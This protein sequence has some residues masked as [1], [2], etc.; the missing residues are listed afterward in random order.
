MTAQLT[1][2]A[3]ETPKQKTPAG[4]HR[5]VAAS[6]AGTVAE[7]YEF[8]L[9]GMAAAL[10]F[11]DVFFKATGNPLDG[12]IAALLTYAIGF[13][14]RPI[15]G[16]IFGHYGDKFGRKKLLQVS[17]LVIGVST[18]LIGAI[19]SFDQIGYA[20]PIILVVLRF[21][22]GIAIGG[23]WGGAVLLVAEQSPDD[24]R[25][26]WASFPQVGAPLGN[27]LA[28]VVL[29]VLSFALPEAAFL[30]W[31]WRVAFFFSAF[32]V[33]IGWFIRTK[34]EDSPIFQDAAE[35]QPQA[36]ST[37]KAIKRVFQARPREV[38]TAMGARVIENILYYM[39]VTFSLTYLKV[40][41][42]VDTSTILTL[43]LISHIVH[44]AMILVFGWMSDKVGRRPVYLAGA[45]LATVYCF[46]AFPLMD[47]KSDALILCAITVGLIIH[48][49]MYAPQPALLSEMFPT[50]MRYIGVSLGAQVTA[51][52]AG[53]LA[54]VIATMLL[55]TFDSW[56]PIA[57]YVAVAGLISIVA[58]LF[59]RETKGTSLAALDDEHRAR[60]G[61][62]L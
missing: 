62:S 46:V 17:L 1:D 16:I 42:D 22:Q 52:F 43:M 32:I 35:E 26:F 41:L 13:V 29:L 15:G 18:F 54:P 36:E 38:L 50:H 27:V 40:Q 5:I 30:S 48:A 53:S 60:F 6:M 57:I 33:L 19:P 49:V 10:V 11:G 14:A 4:F 59:M 7:W 23:E 45:T 39:V 56:V 21:M 55:R 51:I 47:T 12:V 28:T 44:A 25:G 9:Y 31:G 20:A 58:V 37:W 61:T 3:P 34:V 24:K 8:F 2:P